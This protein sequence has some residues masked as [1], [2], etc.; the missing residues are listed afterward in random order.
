MTFLARMIRYLFWVLIVSWTFRLL[1]R[2]VTSMVRKGPATDPDEF[3]A[4]ESV[5]RRL[6]RDPVCGTHL[7]ETIAIP[8]RNGDETLHF[9][10]MECRD[11]YRQG[12]EKL[13]AHA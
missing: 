5:G 10:S 3:V 9:C 12:I 13:A 1:S 2:L 7:A 6:V 8:L 4:S 11:K